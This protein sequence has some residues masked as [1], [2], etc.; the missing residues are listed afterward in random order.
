M[1]TKDKRIF[2]IQHFL[3]LSDQYFRLSKKLAD[4]GLNKEG[5]AQAMKEQS[6]DTGTSTSG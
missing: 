6:K 5:Y 1:N 2:Y 4:G 3:Q